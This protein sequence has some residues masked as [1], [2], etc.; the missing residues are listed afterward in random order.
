MAWESDAQHAYSTPLPS[1]FS[2]CSA[3]A[4]LQ[5]FF[6]MQASSCKTLAS[7]VS[8]GSSHSQLLPP[9]DFTSHFLVFTAYWAGLPSPLL[10]V[11]ILDS[12]LLIQRFCSENLITT[13]TRTRV[14]VNN[15]PLLTDSNLKQGYRC[16]D[17]GAV[18]GTRHRPADEA[19]ALPS[20]LPDHVTWLPVRWCP[21]RIKLRKERT[22]RA[23]PGVPKACQGCE[24]CATATKRNRCQKP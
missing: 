10:F 7:F 21:A 2:S 22:H 6:Y 24:P 19:R 20:P 9:R 11:T 8:I 17:R 15:G 13:I 4:L 23:H 14:L 3:A 18:R 1:S 16:C 5:T 12:M